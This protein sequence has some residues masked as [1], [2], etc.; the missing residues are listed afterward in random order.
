[1]LERVVLDQTADS[2]LDGRSSVA[3]TSFR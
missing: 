3:R 2:D 1:L